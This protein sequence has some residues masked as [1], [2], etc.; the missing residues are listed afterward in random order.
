MCVRKNPKSLHKHKINHHLPQK[1]LHQLKMRNWLKKKKIKLKTMSH[2]KKRAL[3][4]GEMKLIKKRRMNKRFKIKDHLTE[5]STKQFN[6]ITLS[7]PSLVTFKRSNHLLSSC[8][9]L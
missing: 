8:S 9:F 1:H 7:T 6:E 2:L 3:I 5:E 4:K